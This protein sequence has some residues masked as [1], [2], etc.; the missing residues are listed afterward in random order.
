MFRKEFKNWIEDT[1]VYC[2]NIKVTLIIYGLSVVSSISINNLIN[3]RVCVCVLF[4]FDLNVFL[5][6]NIIRL[7]Y[8]R[9]C[10]TDNSFIVTVPFFIRA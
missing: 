3:Y 9:C 7:K 2:D 1:C 5:D 10:L 6:E 4:I 8:I